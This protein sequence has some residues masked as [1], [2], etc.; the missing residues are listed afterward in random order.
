MGGPSNETSRLSPGDGGAAALRARQ[1]PNT[2]ELTA[3]C[4]QML[5]K[6]RA[7]IAEHLDD[8]PEI[9]DWTWKA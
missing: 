7:Y 5:A 3:E 9:R 8:I 4:E 2:R 1:P 6:H